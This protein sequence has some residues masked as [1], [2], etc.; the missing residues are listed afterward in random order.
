MTLL[1]RAENQLKQEHDKLRRSVDSIARAMSLAVDL[2]DPY[3]AGH[4]R[5]VSALACGI[6]RELGQ[7]E[8]DIEIIRIAGLLH[9][10]GKISVPSEILSKPGRLSEAEMTI[11]RTHVQVG[12]DLLKQIEFAPPIALVALQHHER[13]NGSGYPNGLKGD[14][15]IPEAQIMGVADVV[16]AMS[17]HRPYRPALGME[18]A[19]AEVLEHRTDRYASHIVDACMSFFARHGFDLEL[20]IETETI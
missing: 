17:T 14:Q 15:I 4:Q 16:E 6:A 18:Q 20:A 11:V 3:T 8:E 10:V 9:D 12:Y 7:T 19:L 2:R 13:M 5:R 1:R